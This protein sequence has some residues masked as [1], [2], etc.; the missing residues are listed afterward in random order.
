M[1]IKILGTSCPNCKTLEKRV[2]KVVAKNNIE[3]NITKIE[4]ITEI[5]T[6]NIMST[7]GL[8]VNEEVITKGRVPSEREIIKILTK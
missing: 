7:P 8:V 2:R 6:Y 4:D 1:E 5:M 3:A